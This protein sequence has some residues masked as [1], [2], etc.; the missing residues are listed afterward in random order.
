MVIVEQLDNVL[1]VNN[2]LQCLLEWI[3][4]RICCLYVASLLSIC[5]A[6]DVLDKQ[7]NTMRTASLEVVRW[8]HFMQQYPSLLIGGCVVSNHTS[9]LSGFILSD[10]MGNVLSNVLVIVLLLACHHQL[11]E[12]GAFWGYYHVIH[13]RTILNIGPAISCQTTC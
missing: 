9:K 6:K 1:V 3:T 12:E 5:C 10:D 11:K 8:E 2:E 7:M 4:N 13:H